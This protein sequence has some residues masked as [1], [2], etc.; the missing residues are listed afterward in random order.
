M[1]R[2]DNPMPV[3]RNS[4]LMIVPSCVDSCPNTVMEPLYNYV[5]VIGANKSGIPEIL[6]NPERV[7]EMDILNLKKAIKKGLEP[8]IN[9]RIL[10][11]QKIRRSQLMFDGGFRMAEI[12][13]SK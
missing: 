11:L 12:V 1:G 3:I 9:K 10:G 5:P 2:L 13:E 7:F 4:K 6:N 8:E